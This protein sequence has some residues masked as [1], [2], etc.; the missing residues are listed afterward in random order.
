[1][2][3]VGDDTSVI[4][5]Y[6]GDGKDDP[7]LY[8]GGTNTGD[9]S[10]WYYVGSLNNPS[11]GYT[12]VPWGVNGDFP[13][14]G[15]YDGDQKNDFVVQRN[16][17]GQAN[18]WHKYSSGAADQVKRWG[19]ATDVVVPG[20][21]DGDGKTDLAVA[22]SSGGIY[23]W[24]VLNS[25]NQTVSARTWGVSGTDFI[26]QGDYDGDGRT[27]HAVW[28]TGARGAFWIAGSTD[29]SYAVEW[30]TTADYPPANYNVH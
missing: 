21:Y 15:D 19:I 18:F 7:A 20:D 14:P 28:R 9:I 13:A 4:G 1:L 10:Y 22:R 8:R 16:A 26:S 29:G 24:W 3:S 25:S 11:G 2:G 6:D 17:S 27:D 12:S 5:D 23:T 30:G